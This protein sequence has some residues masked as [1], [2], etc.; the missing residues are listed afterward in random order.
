MSIQYT[1]DATTN[2]SNKTFT[3]P[4]GK[5]W[6]LDWLHV[7]YVSTA[8][9]GNR[10]IEV[11][12][13][14]ASDVLRIDFHAGTTQAASLTRHYAFQP[15]IF[16]ETAFVDN[17]IQIAIPMNMILPAGWKIVVYD[18]ASSGAGIDPAADDM[19][20]SFQVTEHAI[21]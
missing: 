18:S 3:V 21:N 20:V 1:Y 8:T 15:G 12:I 11:K 19:T 17:E 5:T 2:D 6:R 14:D 7:L 16:R 13:T 4:T 10:Q 9:V